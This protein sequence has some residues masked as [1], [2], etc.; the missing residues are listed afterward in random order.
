[1][2]KKIFIKFLNILFIVKM[3]SNINTDQ[4]CHT[5]LVYLRTMANEQMIQ[6]HYVD[7]SRSCLKQHLNLVKCFGVICIVS[8]TVLT[9]VIASTT[10]IKR[11]TLLKQPVTTTPISTNI[12]NFV[13]QFD[14]L[15]GLNM[16]VCNIEGTVILDLRQNKSCDISMELRQWLRVKQII[17]L[18]DTAIEEARRY[19]M[20]L[21]QLQH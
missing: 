14:L 18:I 6:E 5:R 10:N 16:T 8:V 3:L 1:M 12:C 19:W 2:K 20:N 17:P 7:E 4:I 11:E 13:K 15:D 9:V 21:Q